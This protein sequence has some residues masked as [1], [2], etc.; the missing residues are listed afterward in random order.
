MYGLVSWQVVAAVPGVGGEV[1]H[2][3]EEVVRGVSV[4]S[5]RRSGKRER[6]RTTAIKIYYKRGYVTL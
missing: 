3:V 4:W 6:S 1:L 5:S 2:V